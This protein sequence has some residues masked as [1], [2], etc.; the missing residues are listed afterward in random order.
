VGVWP[1]K[2]CAAEC[3]WNAARHVAGVKLGA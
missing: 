1:M 3:D 2:S